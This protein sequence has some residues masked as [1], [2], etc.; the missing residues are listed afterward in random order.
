MNKLWKPLLGLVV[1]L[2][3]F[4][5]SFGWPIQNGLQIDIDTS[6]RAQAARQ[7]TPWDLTKLQVMN[8]VIHQVNDDYVDPKRIDHQRM[9]LAGLDAIQ[10]NVAPVLVHYQDGAETL[11][12][13]VNSRQSEFAIR[14]VSSPWELA[15]RFREVF[16]FL[17]EELKNEDDLELSE[18]EYTAV[19]GMLKTLDP[20]TVLLP[21]EM[22][23]E[24]QTSTR[25]E[26]GGLGIV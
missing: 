1:V 15:G 3:A 22:F 6:P 26:F 10:K 24:M 9:M 16:A 12:V 8:R 13:Q 5:V 4:T 14:D 23:D 11:K 19:N 7:K 20:H 2:A 18:I 25:G 17:Q 21:P